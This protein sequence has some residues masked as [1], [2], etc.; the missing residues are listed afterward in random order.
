MANLAGSDY[1][2]VSG[3]S[4]L[5][6]GYDT[7]LAAAVAQYGA[8]TVVNAINTP[9]VDD[10][11]HRAS[12]YLSAK[13]LESTYGAGTMQLTFMNLAGGTNLNGAM[14]GSI[15]TGLPLYLSD[16]IT[17]GAAFLATLNLADADVG[18]FFPGDSTG[19]IPNGGTFN[20]NPLSPNFSLGFGTGGSTTPMRLTLQVGA[21]ASDKLVVEYSQVNTFTLGLTG[22]NLATNYNRVST[23]RTALG[24]AANRLESIMNANGW[25]TEGQLGGYSR[26]VDL[27]MAR[28]VS[29]LARNQLLRDSATAMLVQ[30]NVTSEN[31]IT[32]M[33]SMPSAFELGP[34]GTHGAHPIAAKR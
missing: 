4:S 14:M 31:M 24:A 20:P 10:D 21:N 32:L 27:D 5:I 19:V 29:D 28:E 18:G 3:A 22:I 34:S 26:I 13:Y 6:S 9:W 15:G 33:D 30:A 8:A 12:A 16:F 1:W 25:G 17:N 11:L 7:E 23:T 2:F